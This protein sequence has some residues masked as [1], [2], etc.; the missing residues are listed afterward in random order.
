MHEL[1]PQSH[2]SVPPDSGEVLAEFD[3][4]DSSDEIQILSS[5]VPE[6]PTTHRKHSDHLPGILSRL[7]WLVSVLIVLAILS[8]FVPWI[9]E[10]YHYAITR[11]RI[12]AE[13]DVAI[14]RLSTEPLRQL[15]LASQ[16]VSQRVAPSVVHIQTEAARS[17][18]P[19][20]EAAHLFGPRRNEGHG[21]GSGVIVD[22]AGYIVTNNHVVNGADTIIVTLGDDRRLEAEVIGVDYGT[23]L[24]VI[25]IN[26]DRIIPAEWGNSDDVQVG[27]LVWAVGS[28]FGLQQSVTSGILSA[29]NRAEK[30]GTVYQDF[31]QTDAAVNPGNSGGPLV[32]DRGRVI[33]INTAIVGETYR[34]ISFAIPSTVAKDIYQR[35]RSDGRVARGWLGIQMEEIDAQLASE[36]GLSKAEGALVMRVVQEGGVTSPALVA[37]I[38]EGDVVVRWNNVV[39]DRPTTLSRAVAATRV[40]TAA[41]VEIIREGTTKIVKVVVGERPGRY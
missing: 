26:A 25:K 30:A 33:G 2:L 12:R 39:V 28:P 3:T 22:E 6:K 4:P 8:Y 31:L 20:D 34:G 15:S 38:K 29:K 1:Q 7:A 13:H 18:E 40:G 32:D 35:I 24:A 41:N 37:G 27:S 10:K 14:D 17:D 5:N 16:L 19:E 21:Q 9:A 36:L 11:G 23:D